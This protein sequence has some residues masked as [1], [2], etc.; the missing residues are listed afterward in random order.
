MKNKLKPRDVFSKN[1]E[2]IP[3]LERTEE[4]ASI[5]D[6]LDIIHR[7][8]ASVWSVDDYK[9]FR[10]AIVKMQNLELEETKDLIISLLEKPPVTAETLVVW[11]DVKSDSHL[12]DERKLVVKKDKVTNKEIKCYVNS[13][14]E[15]EVGDIINIAKRI[16]HII[17][18]F[19]YSILKNIYPDLESLPPLERIQKLEEILNKSIIYGGED[20]QTLSSLFDLKFGFL[21]SVSEEY[22][23]IAKEKMLSFAVLRVRALLLKANAEEERHKN[24]YFIRQATDRA[25]AKRKLDSSS[26]RGYG[27]W[28]H[29]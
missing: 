28:K 11:M 9:S 27:C 23:I 12:F 26:K 18:S 22:F 2:S 5:I 10:K 6:I 15:Y 13:R 21:K 16:H 14:R 29:D 8:C 7:K 4:N 24:A 1:L 25:L 20:Y 3:A 19:S 17:S